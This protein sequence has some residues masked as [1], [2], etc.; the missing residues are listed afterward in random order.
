MATESRNNDKFRVVAC[1]SEADKSQRWLWLNGREKIKELCPLD[2][3]KWNENDIDEFIAKRFPLLS[4]DEKKFI[5][6]LAITASLPGY[7]SM[8]SFIYMLRYVFSNVRALSATLWTVEKSQ[9]P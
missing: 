7:N 5:R 6:D 9:S 1:V 8:T 2:V 4:S 3:L